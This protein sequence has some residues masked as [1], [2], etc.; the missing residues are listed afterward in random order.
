MASG[1]PL[2]GGAIIIPKK[3][4]PPNLKTW[5]R[6]CSTIDITD[7]NRASFIFQCGN[8]HGYTPTG[9][10]SWLHKHVTTSHGSTRSL[11]VDRLGTIWICDEYVQCVRTVRTAVP[12][13]IRAKQPRSVCVTSSGRTLLIGHCNGHYRNMV[14]LVSVSDG[15]MRQICKVPAKPTALTL[16]RDRYMV[17]G[18]SDG[19]LQLYD[20]GTLLGDQ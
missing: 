6:L 9:I 20:L 19:G 2:K 13:S 10:L 14:S 12:I 4:D 11:T 7:N 15:R 3:V 8:L 5:I 17:V 16:Y 18:M 1:K